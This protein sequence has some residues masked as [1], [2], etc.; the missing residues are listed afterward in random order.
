MDN[1]WVSMA[2]ESEAGGDQSEETKELS[3]QQGESIKGKVKSRDRN[4]YRGQRCSSIDDKAEG[5][6]EEDP[7]HEP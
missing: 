2:S 7:E 3:H 6:G 5:A 4:Q 1:A